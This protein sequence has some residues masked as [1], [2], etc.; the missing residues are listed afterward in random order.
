MSLGGI[1]CAANTAATV[2]PKKSS[3]GKEGKESREKKIFD[4]T[5]GK[6]KEGML[7]RDDA[8]DALHAGVTSVR[9]RKLPM[10][11]TSELRWGG[12]GESKK[13]ER[14]GNR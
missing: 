10:L 14:E 13:N 6:K 8:C 7:Q 12:G 5:G 2:F 4:L 1:L 9:R 3:Q 11:A